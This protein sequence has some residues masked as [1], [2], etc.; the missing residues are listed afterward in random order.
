MKGYQAAFIS[1]S[2]GRVCPRLIDDT[3]SAAEQARIAY[4]GLLPTSSAIERTVRNLVVK[5]YDPFMR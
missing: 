1:C 4:S 3:A 5:V 2:K